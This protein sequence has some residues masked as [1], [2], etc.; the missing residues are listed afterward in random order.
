M[1]VTHPN[2]AFVPAPQRG[3]VDSYPQLAP[4]LVAIA[5]FAASVVVALAFT[6][7]PG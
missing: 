5:I 6:G 4:A 7:L 3:F 2:T 1:S